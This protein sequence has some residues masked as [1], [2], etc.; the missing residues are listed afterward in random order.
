MNIGML[1]TMMGDHLAVV[2]ESEKLPA[3][4]VPYTL[5]PDGL[6]LIGEAADPA[7]ADETATAAASPL[8]PACVNGKTN[9]AAQDR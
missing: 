1:R 2:Q 9:H 7:S 6:S 8:V 3:S 4:T 5:S